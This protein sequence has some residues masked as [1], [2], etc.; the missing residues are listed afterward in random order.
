MA[1]STDRADAG[2]FLAF[3]QGTTAGALFTRY[4]FEPAR[5]R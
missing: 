4:G 5:R 1:S 2:R 3:L